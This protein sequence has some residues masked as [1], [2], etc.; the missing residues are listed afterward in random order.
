M[1]TSVALIGFMATGKTAVGQLL[2]Q[3]LGKQFI[4]L[5]ALIVQKAGK[6][7]ADIFEQD[8]ELTFRELEIEV[9]RE[10]SGNKNQVIACGGGII[11]NRL[12]ID[13]LKKESVIVYLTASP[14]VILKRASS[15]STVRPLLEGDNKA[16]TIREL[17]RFRRPFYDR[18]ADIKID[19]TGLDIPATAE[20]IIARLKEYENFH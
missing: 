12:N 2:A 13:R 5:D 8:G 9:T 3:R 11:L 14:D 16:K 19:T 4:E 15:D 20:Q 7:I 10:V 17:L 18:A 6:K 1:K